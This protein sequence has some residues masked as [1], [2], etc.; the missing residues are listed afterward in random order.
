MKM[1]ITSNGQVTIPRAVRERAGLHPHTE[2]EIFLVEGGVRIVK[3]VKAPVRDRGDMAIE[4]LRRS[5]AHV[6]MSTD[7][8]M[9]LTRGDDVDLD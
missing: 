7:E 2:V 3:V 1:R 9:A 8:M 5:A 4:R 6:I